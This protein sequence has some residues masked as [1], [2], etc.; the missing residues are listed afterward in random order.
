MIRGIKKSYIVFYIGL[1]I[2]LSVLLINLFLFKNVSFLFCAIVPAIS[3]FIFMFIYGYERKI[4]RFTHETI[5]YVFVYTVL[6]LLATY[7]IGIFSGFNRSIYALNM[8]NIIHNIIPYILVILSGEYLRNEVVRKCENSLIGYTLVAIILIVIDCTLYL[9]TFDLSVGDEQI[10][11]ICNILL[12]SVSKNVFLIY[13]AKVGGTLPTLLY[14]G[15]TELKLFILPFFPSFGLYIDS[16][17]LTVIPVVIG[18]L[19]Y[20]SLK[21]FQN[22]EIE[23][24]TLKSSKLYS[25]TSVI[26]TL[27]IVVG[28]VMLTSC[29]FNYGSIAIGSGSMTGTINKGDVIVFKQLGDYEVKNGDVMVFRKDGKLIVHRIIDI[30]EINEGEYVYYTKGDANQDPDGYPLKREELVGVVKFRITYLGLPSVEL[31]ELIKGKK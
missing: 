11:F 18:F 30:L 2:T 17:V 21:Q 19:I 6:Y 1:L 9:T 20:I 28:I 15:L 26:I 24:K 7:I 31:S 27:V 16:V 3:F 23:G 10:K 13:V 29:K 22:K 4:K 14:R 8:T 12:P 5:F 25:Y